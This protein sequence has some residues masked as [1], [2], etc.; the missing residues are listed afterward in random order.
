[1]PNQSTALA[2]GPEQVLGQL[3]TGATVTRLLGLAAE[4]KIADRLREGARTVDE[5]AA[6]LDFEPEALYR[7]MRALASHGVFSEV[8]PRTFA[9][10]PAAELLRSDV[11]GSQRL[12]A[13]FNSAQ[14]YWDAIGHIGHSL[15]TGEPAFVD[16]YEQSSFEF[17]N[18]D[19]QAGRLF[20]SMMTQ[21]TEE[22]LPVILERYDFSPFRH[23]VD[24][25]AAQGAL[26]LAVM[27]QHPQM[28]GTLFDLAVVVAR[29]RSELAESPLADRLEFAA[30][31]F[32]EA[33]PEGADAYLLKY[34]IHDWDDGECVSILDNCRQAMAPEGKVLVIENV[35]AS[36]DEP[37]PGKMLDLTM[38]LM[39]GGRER[40]ADEFTMLFEQA[41]LR[42]TRQIPLAGSMHILEAERA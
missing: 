12:W 15:K 39:E 29:L 10:T 23:V 2:P 26:L 34:I 14:W 6:G 33:V 38:M 21:M 40:T 11:P 31:N 8:E 5:L 7:A 25:G 3:I 28:R 1:M 17:Y 36:G 4:H 27:G 16:L 24:V 20:Y 32:F 42:M 19:P 13:M 30:G 41:G 18:S 37:C 35:I 9:L 22:L